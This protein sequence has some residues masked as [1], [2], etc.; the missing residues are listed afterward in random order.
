M[1]KPIVAI[2]SALGLLLGLG[3]LGGCDQTY[4]SDNSASAQQHSQQA[5]AT[6]AK[7]ANNAERAA[8]DVTA[9]VTAVAKGV[10][11]GVKEGVRQGQRDDHSQQAYND[12]SQS[13]TPPPAGRERAPGD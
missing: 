11:K 1:S 10:E 5:R 12:R 9:S 3:A 2:G 13:S 7:V 6:T 4:Q 8:R